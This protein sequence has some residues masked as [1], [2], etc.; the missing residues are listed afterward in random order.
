ML[1]KFFAFASV[2]DAGSDSILDGEQGSVIPRN[3]ALTQYYPPNNGFSGTPQRVTLGPGTVVD[4]YGPN[5]G[6][7]AS[8]Y[9]TPT[10]ARS[11]PYGGETQPY[12]AFEVIKPLDVDVGNAAAWFGQP[13]GGRQ[14]MFDAPIQ[15]YLDNGFLRMIK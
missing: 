6:V 8:P 7:F 12:H 14:F 11:L 15:D 9:G 1:T 5:E 10:W 4:R 3:R 13:G 2:A